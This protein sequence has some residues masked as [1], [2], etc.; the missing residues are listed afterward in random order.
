EVISD[1]LDLS[2]LE[3]DKLTLHEEAVELDELI[4]RCARTVRQLAEEAGIEI[5]A[6]APELPLLRGDPRMLRQMLLNLLSNA[7]K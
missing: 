5:R 6:R 2:R 7:I 3:L 4:A 1:I